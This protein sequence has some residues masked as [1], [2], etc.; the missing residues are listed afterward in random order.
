MTVKGIGSG[1]KYTWIQIP[2]LPSETESPEAI[3]SSPNPQLAP[4]VN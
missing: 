4:P 2:A 1:A 3:L